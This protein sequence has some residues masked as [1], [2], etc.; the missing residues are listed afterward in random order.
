MQCHFCLKIKLTQ[1]NYSLGKKGQKLSG[2]SS[3]QSSRKGSPK[4]SPRNSPLTVKPVKK[5]K[6]LDDSDD[7]KHKLKRN[8][9]ST[10]KLVQDS[11]SGNFIY[12]FSPFIQGKQ[13]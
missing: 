1:L 13:N 7:D 10:S 11:K 2:N 3:R 6:R 5:R 12:L 8:A 4:D 9:K